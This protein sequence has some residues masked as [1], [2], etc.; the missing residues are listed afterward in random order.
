[1]WIQASENE[2]KSAQPKPARKNSFGLEHL[3]VRMFRVPE[4]EA[5]LIVFP[6]NT[7]WLVDGGNTSNEPSNTELAKVLQTH[8]ESRPLLKLEVCV[9]SHSHMDH[10]GALE[11]LLASGSSALAPRVTVYRATGAWHR[12]AKF[13]DRYHQMVRE[14]N[15]VVEKIFPER[16]EEIVP[17]ANH[18]E[19][20]FFVGTGKSA[21]ASLWMRLRYKSARL[22]FT[23]DSHQPY[24][25]NLIKQFSAGHLRA[26]V[27]KVTHHGSSS[28]TS[29]QSVAAAKPAFAIT[30]S[31]QDDPDHRLEDD[32][33]AR[34]LEPPG[35]KRR[36]FNT[37]TEGEIVVKTD[38]ED[39]GGAI[40]YQ[41]S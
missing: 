32:T 25:R 33:K 1:M 18:A 29:T 13:L 28:G 14:Q 35:V 41:V 27:L 21:Y 6:D 4:G 10:I 34:I 31:S 24:E 36:I 2:Y 23:G 22:L 5:I 15:G 20:H 38:G 39:Y 7:V 8:L 40:L 19:A 17:I 11:T 9:A 16:T 12:K 37:D 26:D 3:E 30:S